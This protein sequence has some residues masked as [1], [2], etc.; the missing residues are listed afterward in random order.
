MYNMEVLVAPFEFVF[1]VLNNLLVI[2]L[3]V[4]FTNMNLKF[5][6]I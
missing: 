5:S 1:K 4:I 6:P 2:N 3:I